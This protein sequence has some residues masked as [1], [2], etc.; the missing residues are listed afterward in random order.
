MSK[1]IRS[2]LVFTQMFPKSGDDAVISGMIKNPFYQTLSLSKTGCNVD[3]IS[4]GT[5]R[6]SYELDGVRVFSIGDGFLKGMVKSFSYELKM[7]IKYLSL[8]RNN[9]YDVIHVHH[10]NVPWLG[11]LKKTGLLKSHLVYTAH[12]TSTPELKAARQ[13]SWLFYFLLTV[14][15]KLQ[16]ILDKWC[17]KQA[18]LLLSP[19][20]FQIKE[21][22]ELYAVENKAVEVVYNGYDENLYYKNEDSGRDIRKKLG[23]GEEDKVVIFVGRVA[24]KKGIDLLI[25][26]MDE[27]R[28]SLPDAKLIIVMGFIGRQKDYKDQIYAMA[29]EREDVLL[30][31]NVP[32]SQLASYYNAADLCVVPSLGYESIPTVIY[33]AMACGVPVLTQ[34]SWGI[35]EVLSGDFLKESELKNKTLPQRIIEL[36]SDDELLGRYSSENLKN[37]KQFSWGDGGDKLLN[38]FNKHLNDE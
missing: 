22:H 16:H 3:V 5:S 37:A 18:E 23:I 6:E 29:L 30:C 21:M 24:R 15:G 19:S 25:N 11:L 8:A 17:W 12:G 2:A 13:G 38:I 1:G 33:E 27:V 28:V 35:P 10:L 7:F 26:A 32:E 9:N 36:L 31:E 14:N 4:T 34:G 20:A